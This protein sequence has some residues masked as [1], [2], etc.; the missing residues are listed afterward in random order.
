ML[1][2]IKTRNIVILSFEL[3]K[4]ERKPIIYMEENAPSSMDCFTRSKSSG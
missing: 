2:E 1:V 3:D 4:R